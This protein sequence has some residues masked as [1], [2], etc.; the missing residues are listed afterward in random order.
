MTARATVTQADLARALDVLEK[1]GAKVKEIIVSRDETRIVLADE[2]KKLR[3]RAW[4][5]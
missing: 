4:D 5:D 3:P 2:K 1:R